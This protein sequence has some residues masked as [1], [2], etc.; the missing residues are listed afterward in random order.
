MREERFEDALALSRG[1]L[2]AGLDDDWVYERRDEH[3]DCVA[4]ALARLAAR[5]ED[6]HDLEAAI[7]WTRRQAALDPLAEEPQRELMRRLA[8]AGDR[9]GAIRVFERLT[10]RLRDELR[11]VPSQATREPRSGCARAK[12]RRQRQSSRSQQPSR[13]VAS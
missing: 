3:R 7:A 2:L 11:I 10:Q 13:R 1:E 6:E 12:Q 9:S 4:D 5:A 8:T